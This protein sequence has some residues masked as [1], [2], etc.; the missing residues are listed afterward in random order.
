MTI[1]P[2][3]GL[4][5]AFFSAAHESIGQKRKYTFEPYFNHCL[6]VAEI[7]SQVTDDENVIIAAAGHDTKEDVT[8]INPYYSLDLIESNFGLRVK[9]MVIDLTDIYTKK[10]Y[11]A[12]NR[13]KRKQ[14]ERERME[15]V[16]PDSQT[17]KLADLISN[18]RSIVTYDKD[19]AR[20]YL[21]EKLALLPYL[22]G[23][24]ESLQRQ[25]SCLAM[26]GILSLG[27]TTVLS[28]GKL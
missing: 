24:N 27:L 15:L 12:W 7:V 4:A 9:N 1:T 8:P 3:I 17:I 11:P 19:F 20:V 21:E 2:R 23:G 13:A 28:S 26:D 10:V 22:K 18:T 6:E 14:A 5:I 25:A 16:C